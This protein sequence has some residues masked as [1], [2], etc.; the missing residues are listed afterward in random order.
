MKATGYL[1]GAAVAALGM[2]TAAC[3]A[4]APSN[5]TTAAGTANAAPASGEAVSMPAGLTADE[6]VIW[7]SLTTDAQRRAVEFIAAGGTFRQFV[8]L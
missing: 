1:R 8:S 4:P 6:Q 3:E 2:T 5:G 7:N